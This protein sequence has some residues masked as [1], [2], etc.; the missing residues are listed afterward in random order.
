MQTK[1]SAA[2]AYVEEKNCVKLIDTPFVLVYK[3]TFDL[4]KNK[5][6]NMLYQENVIYDVL[7]NFVLYV[8]V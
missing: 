5:T 4:N 6:T 3:Y 7:I 2:Y 1:N 8:N